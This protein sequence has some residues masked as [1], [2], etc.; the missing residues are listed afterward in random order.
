L[1]KPAPEEGIE[2][3]ETAALLAELGC[4]EGQGYYWSPAV[5][6]EK[7]PELLMKLQKPN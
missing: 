1:K 6:E 2:N 7:L 3:A 5:P 4:N